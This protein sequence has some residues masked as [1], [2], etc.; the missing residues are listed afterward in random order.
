MKKL[1]FIAL[2]CATLVSC[3]PA[4]YK[5]MFES[6]E[7]INVDNKIGLKFSSGDTVL[8]KNEIYIMDGGQ[9]L[10]SYS[11]WGVYTG[12]LPPESIEENSR[13]I[14]RSRTWYKPA[15]IYK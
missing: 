6:G 14:R 9:L 2:L 13:G 15:V 7:I 1:L 3:T 8:I 5:V 12:Y 4:N 10:S 11:I